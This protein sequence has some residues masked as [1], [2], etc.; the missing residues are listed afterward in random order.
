MSY[1]LVW[2]VKAWKRVCPADRLDTSFWTPLLAIK[3]TIN[4][5]EN[6]IVVFEYM[7]IN[8]IKIINNQNYS[9]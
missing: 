1:E 6:I 4:L 9:N 2:F 5:I 3:S 8:I 7:I